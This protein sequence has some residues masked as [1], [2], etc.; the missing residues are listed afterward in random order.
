MIVLSTKACTR[1]S[2]LNAV[3]ALTS[4]GS[5]R[6]WNTSS[7][8]NN[9]RL[10]TTVLLLLTQLLQQLLQCLLPLTAPLLPSL[11]PQLLRS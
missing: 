5:A 9:S 7:C 2:M 4:K 8:L 11:Q 10:S 1:P 3:P 6:I